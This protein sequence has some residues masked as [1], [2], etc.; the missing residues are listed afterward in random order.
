[1]RLISRN[2]KW[3]A[4]C[5]VWDGG[6]VGIGKRARML[7][8]TGVR[9]D[10]SSIAK[11][12]AEAIAHKIEAELNGVHGNTRARQVRRTKPLTVSAAYEARIAS[13]RR[14]NGSEASVSI[15]LRECTHP[16]RF[17]GADRDLDLQ[18]I[19]D[20][21]ADWYAD[22]AMGLR[23]HMDGHENTCPRKAST[24]FRELLE[25]RCGLEALNKREKHTPSAAGVDMSVVVFEMP[26][27]GETE[28]PNE[29]WLT[30]EQSAR[31]FEHLP[32]CWREHYLMHRMMG[33]SYSELY[34][35][36]SAD[37]MGDRVRVRGT[38]R[39]QR[40]RVLPVPTSLREVLSRR[41]S[42]AVPGKPLFEVWTL[43]AKELTRAAERA[44]VVPM[45]YREDG[46][47]TRRLRLRKAE[48]ERV[49][50][51][52]KPAPR[53]RSSE[54]RAWSISVNVLRAS[55]C[56]ELVSHDVHSKKISNLMGHNTVATA[57]RWYTRL[58]GED[59]GDVAELVRNPSTAAEPAPA[60]DPSAGRVNEE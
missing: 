6:A 9:D 52:G 37:V 1:M 33:L 56:T 12:T 49:D 2:G 18:P 28:H 29:L 50:K 57:N 17:F 36:H 16:L 20:A 53:K 59:L 44:G 11:R 14:R 45:G 35:I 46:P 38:K 60:L 23:P 41:A 10:G 31:L 42:S 39:R 43:P 21:D 27:L 26:D 25:L 15:T 40:D 4:E 22:Y 5:Y 3:S 58:R 32:E 48:H 19:T 13:I 55:F 34:K 47:P 24:V 8:A 7:R 51:Q 54:A 30:P